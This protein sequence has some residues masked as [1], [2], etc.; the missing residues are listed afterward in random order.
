MNLDQG[1]AFKVVQGATIG[2]ETQ[3]GAEPYQ[4]PRP[5]RIG[6]LIGGAATD[7]WAES[8]NSPADAIIEA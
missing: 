4:Q 6:P 8:R 5:R 1:H 7:G 3:L 2:V